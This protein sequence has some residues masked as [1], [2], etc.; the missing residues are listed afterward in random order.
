MTT[1]TLLK[2]KL[3]FIFIAFIPNRNA[4]A[5]SPFEGSIGRKIILLMYI[6]RCILTF[7]NL[8]YKNT[9]NSVIQS[10]CL[11]DYWCDGFINTNS[12][13]YV[14]YRKWSWKPNTSSFFFFEKYRLC[15]SI[16]WPTYSISVTSNT[17]AF[18]GWFT[19]PCL[20][21]RWYT[22]LTFMRWL[23]SVSLEIKMSL[24]TT[25]KCHM[26]DLLKTVMAILL[27]EYGSEPF[28]SISHCFPWNN[29]YSIINCSLKSAFY[30][31][32]SLE[33]SRSHV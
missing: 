32:W 20:R 11:E 19:K 21:E 4:P 5:F 23:S 3:L 6:I 26:L 16:N 10:V 22:V 18:L 33:I 30:S 29:H 1:N 15:L 17:F 12:L 7:I 31:K 25:H 8:L 27:W 14:F 24:Y 2:R 9:I 28:A 13:C